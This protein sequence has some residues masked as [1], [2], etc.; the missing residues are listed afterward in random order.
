MNFFIFII[1]KAIYIQSTFNKFIILATNDLQQIN[2]SHL[3]QETLISKNTET[4]LN[5]VLR[6]LKKHYFKDLR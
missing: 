1:M 5:R 4:V 2:A 6:R 3:D